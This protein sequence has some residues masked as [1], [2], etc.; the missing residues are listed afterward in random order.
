MG[1]KNGLKE[2]SRERKQWPGKDLEVGKST[3]QVE[4]DMDAV[5]GW[6][7]RLVGCG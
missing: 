5:A 1:R 6:K 4:E 2:S 3:E 7:R